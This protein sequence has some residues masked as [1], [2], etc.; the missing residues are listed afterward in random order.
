MNLRTLTNH[1]APTPPAVPQA[2]LE[3]RLAP[4]AFLYLLHPHPPAAV[5]AHQLACALLLAA[6]EGEEEEEEEEMEGGR[7]EPLAAY[8]VRRSLE[9]WCSGGATVAPPVASAFGQ[10]S[11]GEGCGMQ[12]L[13]W[14][15]G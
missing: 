1:L 4:L 15:S 7:R 13:W 9:G 14:E 11:K 6:L 5:A 3:Q 2:A 8:Y 10:V 12:V